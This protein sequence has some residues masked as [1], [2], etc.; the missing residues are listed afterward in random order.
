METP[1]TGTPAPTDP[2][3]PP[4]AYRVVP[5][6]GGF[7]IRDPLGTAIDRASTRERAL[8]VALALAATAGSDVVEPYAC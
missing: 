2:T 4:R 8:A 5:G 3:A 6:F 1:T 7:V